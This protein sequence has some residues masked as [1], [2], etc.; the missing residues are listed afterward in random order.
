MHFAEYHTPYFATP[1]YTRY[2][3]GIWFDPDLVI[4]HW[5]TMNT[6]YPV[7]KCLHPVPDSTHP[8]YHP[9][10]TLQHD[11]KVGRAPGGGGGTQIF[12]GGCVPRRFQNVGSRERIFLENWGSWERKFEK[13][14]YRELEFWPKHGWKSKNFLKI[15]NGVI[16]VAHWRWIGGLGSGDWLEKGGHDR[17]TSAYPFPMWVTSPG[18]SLTTRTQAR[19]PARMLK[20]SAF[21]MLN[22]PLWCR[23]LKCT[24]RWRLLIAMLP[25]KLRRNLP[26]GLVLDSWISTR[27][28]IHWVSSILS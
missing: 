27:R 4:A 5:I 20:I 21:I 18:A 1:R 6:P 24:Q 25:V 8:L 13:F 9:H 2:D 10:D 22:P 19:N 7:W 26:L 3:T 28:T 23:F 14:G 11:S 17:G 12:F 16:R 15:E